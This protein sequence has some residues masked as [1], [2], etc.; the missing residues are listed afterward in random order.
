MGSRLSIFVMTIPASPDSSWKK[1]SQLLRSEIISASPECT[2]VAVM[3]PFFSSSCRNASLEE[4]PGHRILLFVLSLRKDIVLLVSSVLASA[5]RSVLALST[6]Y[7][8]FDCCSADVFLFTAVSILCCSP[9]K[10]TSLDLFRFHLERC[11]ASC[12]RSQNMQI[13][14]DWD[15]AI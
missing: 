5:Q 1:G 10:D 6:Q 4:V 3:I 12:G 9:D 7:S 11:S 15:G 14:S 13:S 2:L 8:V